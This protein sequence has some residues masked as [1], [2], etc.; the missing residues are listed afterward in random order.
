MATQVEKKQPK[1]LIFPNRDIMQRDWFPN[2]VCHSN[3]SFFL[4]EIL[5]CSL[6]SKLK[7]TTLL[8]RNRRNLALSF[9]NV[10]APEQIQIGEVS[11]TVN[12]FLKPYFIC[13]NIL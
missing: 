2:D 6:I 9:E 1:L 4:H 12:T 11:Y 13:I 7:E 5:C 10:T 3:Y 8:A